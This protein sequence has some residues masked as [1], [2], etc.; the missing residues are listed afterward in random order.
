MDEIPEVV[1]CTLGPDDGR[2]R[3]RR[4][5]SLADLAHPVAHRAGGVLRVV[6]DDLP[7]VAGE[8]RALAAAERECCSWGDWRVHAEGGGQVLEVEAGPGAEDALA[9]LAGLFGTPAG[10]RPAR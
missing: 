1:A 8:L 2:A 7:G 3:M 10:P 6:Y 4:W 5:K 9:A